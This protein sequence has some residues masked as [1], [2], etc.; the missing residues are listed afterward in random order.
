MNKSRHTYTTRGIRPVPG[1]EQTTKI[2][3]RL[4]R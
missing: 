4:N 2:H 1:N 3:P